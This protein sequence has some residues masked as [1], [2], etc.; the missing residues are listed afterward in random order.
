MIAINSKQFNLE[1][2]CACKNAKQ[3]KNK[4]GSD[5]QTNFGSELSNNKYNK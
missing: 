5:E 3:N 1:L 2:V 4:N